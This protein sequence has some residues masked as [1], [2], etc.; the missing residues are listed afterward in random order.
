MF[1][2]KITNKIT[3]KM[4]IGQT[5]QKL[6]DRWNDHVYDSKTRDTPL[7]RS[8][9]KYGIENFQL[10]VIVESK[11]RIELNVLEEHY[12]KILNTVSPNGYNLLPGGLN[13]KCHEDTKLKISNALK[14]RPIKNRW[15]KGNHVS[16]SPETRAKIASKL[17]G[18]TLEHRWNGGNTRPRTEAQKAHLRQLNKGKPNTALYKAVID[19]NGVIYESVNAAAKANKINRVTVSQALKSGKPTRSGLSFKFI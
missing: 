12:I 6:K 16:P 7:Y 8:I 14:G 15:N 10:D 1:I 2:Y 19:S 4:Y 9:R 17:S 5:T 3:G 11:D 13:K 18:R